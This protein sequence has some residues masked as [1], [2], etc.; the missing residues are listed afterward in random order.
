[1]R[2]EGIDVER[3]TDEQIREAFRL[4]S[5]GEAVKEAI[6]E[7]V[8]WLSKHEGASVRDAIEELEL[9][10]ISRE[11]LELMI[12]NL[13][14]EHRGFVEER[15]KDAFGALMG[16]VMERVRGRVEARLV[17]EVLRKRLDEFLK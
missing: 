3:V 5:T 17:A 10:M 2:R 1:L 6:P 8:G 4:V 9:G 15:G 12:E 16:M 7:I 14:K 13:L 11:E